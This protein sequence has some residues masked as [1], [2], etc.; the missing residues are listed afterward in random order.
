VDV[1]LGILL[2]PFSF[3]IVIFVLISLFWA[4]IEI[5]SSSSSQRK[6]K[7][8]SSPEII[9]AEFTKRGLFLW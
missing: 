1:F 7:C 8:R 5:R 9:G 3:L 6:Y 2:A 4:H